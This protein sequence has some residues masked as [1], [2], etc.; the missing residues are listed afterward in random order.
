MGSGPVYIDTTGLMSP[1]T[2]S[3]AEEGVSGRHFCTAALRPRQ[4]VLSPP[5]LS[6]GRLLGQ[7]SLGGS[8]RDWMLVHRSM[9]V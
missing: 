7:N 8:R 3:K 4:Q 1:I 5:P 9:R 6:C 2:S